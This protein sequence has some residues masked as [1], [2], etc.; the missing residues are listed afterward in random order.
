MIDSDKLAV[1]QTVKAGRRPRGVLVSPDGKNLYICAS[2]ENGVEVLDTATMKLVRTLQSGP[3]SGTIR[4]Q[5]SGNPLYIANE[6]NSQVTV[7][8]VVKNQV[9][10]QRAGRRRA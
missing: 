8:D 3:R 2:D 5:P 9:L 7:L 6:N 1:V 10:A 4:A